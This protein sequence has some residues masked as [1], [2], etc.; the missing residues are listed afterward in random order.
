MRE[1]APT[2]RPYELMTIL[3]P[4]VADDAV[5]EQL[6]VIT[7]YVRTAGGSVYQALYEAP[8]G[9]RRF[10]YPIR[11]NGRDVRDGFYSVVHFDLVPSQVFEVE[12]DLKLDERVL[13]FMLTLNDVKDVAEVAPAPE[14]DAPQVEAPAAVER[15][16][17]AAGDL[18]RSAAEARAAAAAARAA[19]EAARAAAE[20]ARP[21]PSQQQREERENREERQRAA[22]QAA[23]I[24]AAQAEAAATAAA[25]ETAP[26]A[27][28]AA[29]TA[30]TDD[31]PAIAPAPETT[32]APAITSSPDVAEAIAS[33]AETPET[34]TTP[35]APV[36]PETAPAVDDDP[37]RA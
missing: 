5:M 3:S 2:A 20:A 17:I 19:S 36:D 9:R 11:H 29:E 35:D 26:T 4:D 27:A 23:A 1:Y 28:P 8:W 6:E 16:E 14:G 30:A 15:N 13:R 33:P 7:G 18:I 10:A 24:E 34:G 32:D 12:R 21:Q 25:T 37:S 31:A 22:A